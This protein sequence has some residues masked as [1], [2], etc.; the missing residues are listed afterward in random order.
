MV[1]T[2]NVVA[3]DERGEGGGSIL[4]SRL[5]AAESIAHQRG[6]TAITVASCLHTSIDTLLL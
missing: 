4:S 2:A 5:Q 3:W 6:W 1:R